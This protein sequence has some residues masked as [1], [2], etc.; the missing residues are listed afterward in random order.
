[1]KANV[2]QEEGMSKVGGMSDTPSQVMARIFTEKARFQR[3]L[4]VEASLA[5]A[6]AGLGIIPQDAADQIGRKAHTEFFD[7]ARYREV[8]QQTTHPI[9]AFLRVFQPAVGAA[10]QYVHLGATTQ[11]IVDT[12]TMMALKAADKVIYGGLRDIEEKLLV[13][14]E[15]HADTIMAG[16]THNVQ[17]LPITFGYKVAVWAREIRRNIE[18]LK[19]CRNRVFVVQLSGAVGTMAAFGPEGPAIQAVVARELDLGVPDIAWHASRDRLVEYGN[20]LALIA[21]A[22]GRIGQEVYLLMGTEVSEVCEP[23]EK[24]IVGSSTMPHKINPQLAEQMMSLARKIRYNA[25]FLGEVAMVDHERNLEH[26]LGEIEKIEESCLTIGQLL[27]CAQEM[28]E[29]M[30]VDAPRMKKNLGLLKG[31]MLS[32][33]IMIELGKKIGKQNAHEV[34]YDD[35]TR[36]LRENVDF[37]K[38]L[39]DDAR[40]SECLS[41]ADIERFLNPADYVGLAPNMAR[42]VVLLSREEREQ[43]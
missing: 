21:L 41:P 16:R 7:F 37:S 38:V 12:G 19:E 26:F 27:T 5:R 40:V 10:G 15:R 29:H 14:A 4:D 1:M 30:T 17:A 6:Q 18:R 33:S 39:A 9:V 42:Q 28:A 8:F 22:L 24:G 23:W 20:L 34:V 36:A 32:E 31:L 11:D 43:D 35:A 2:K 13:L 3:W 25:S